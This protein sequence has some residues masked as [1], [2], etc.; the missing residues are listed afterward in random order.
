MMASIGWHLV[1]NPAVWSGVG[2][3]L[4]YGNSHA[5]SAGFWR[6]VGVTMLASGVVY[7][8]SAK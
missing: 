1:K 3:L 8:V 7:T 5:P 2:L 6:A 4:R